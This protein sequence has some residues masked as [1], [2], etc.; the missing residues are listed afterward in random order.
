M[1]L[2]SSVGQEA[3]QMAV[4]ASSGLIQMAGAGAER[5]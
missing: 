3:V 5:A 2:T 4:L 1:M